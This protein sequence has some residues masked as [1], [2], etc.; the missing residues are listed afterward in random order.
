MRKDGFFH[1]VNPYT[2]IWQNEHYYL[3]ANY[4]KY[5]DLSHYRLDRMKSLVISDDKRKPAKEL[6]GSNADLQIEQYVRASLYHYGGKKIK[7]TL[8]VKDALV[9]DFGTD[10]YFR[11]VGEEYQVTVDV[12]DGEDLYYRLLQ[13]EKN[14][15]VISPLS[16]RDH[17]IEKA[18]GILN[19]YQEDIND[20][21]DT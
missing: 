7:L 1:T 13:Y 18:A 3:I 12:M 10:L 17:I 14:V 20:E 11:A 16:V 21:T 15:K 19:L 8:Q 6:L 9:D 2:L 5:D 4:D